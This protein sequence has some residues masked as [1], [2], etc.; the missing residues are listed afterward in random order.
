M[1]RILYEYEGEFHSVIAISYF[2]YEDLPFIMERKNVRSR[3]AATTI[4]R[5]ISIINILFPENNQ[6]F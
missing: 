3:H 4:K 6:S 1:G 5:N 2:T